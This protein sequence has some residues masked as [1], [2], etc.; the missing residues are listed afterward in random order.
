DTAVGGVV[1]GG[2]ADAHPPEDSRTMAP[3][4]ALGIASAERP[5]TRRRRPDGVD[6]IAPTSSGQGQSAAG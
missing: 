1:D 6:S 2:L 3:D 4:G 5:A